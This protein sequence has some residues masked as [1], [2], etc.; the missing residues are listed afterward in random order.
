MWTVLKPLASKQVE[1]VGLSADI[2]FFASALAAPAIPLP[3]QPSLERSIR[4]PIIDQEHAPI[5]GNPYE[6]ARQPKQASQ[7]LRSN[8]QSQ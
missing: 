1:V 2:G 7:P 4:R 6:P 3:A 5:F 8:S